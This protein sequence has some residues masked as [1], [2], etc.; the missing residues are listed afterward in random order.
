M[1]KLSKS[2]LS[3]RSRKGQWFIISA[4]FISSAFL[5]ISSMFGG[6]FLT[7]LSSAVTDEDNYYKDIVEDLNRIV[8]S[9]D[10]PS[11]SSELEDIVKDYETF[12]EDRLKRMGIST[13]I[14]IDYTT[15]QC[16]NINFIISMADQDII[17]STS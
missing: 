15:L 10:C 6:Y 7:D 12:A 2:S 8:Y 9:P 11:Y 14:T 16:G 5:V 13:S 4:V 1:P 17:I 3:I